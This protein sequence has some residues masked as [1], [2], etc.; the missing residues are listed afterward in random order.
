MWEGVVVWARQ[1]L[2]P[3]SICQTFKPNNDFAFVGGKSVARDY[4][5][6]DA[7]QAGP[8]RVK[9][10]QIRNRTFGY[11]SINHHAFNIGM[12]PPKVRVK[13]V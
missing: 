10:S 1:V 4:L 12:V 11:V 6:N 3:H 7:P 2:R 13:K 9:I 5:I 8:A